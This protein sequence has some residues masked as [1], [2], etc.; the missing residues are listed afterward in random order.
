[1]IFQIHYLPAAG[2]QIPKITH[3]AEVVTLGGVLWRCQILRL[4][5]YVYVRRSSV[6]FTGV[7]VLSKTDFT[8]EVVI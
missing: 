7:F 2:R 8:V 3:I 4:L 1:M 6:A 5:L